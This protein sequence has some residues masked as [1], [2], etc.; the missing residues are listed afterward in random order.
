MTTPT[1]VSHTQLNVAPGST[2]V[3]RDAEW[4]VTNTEATQDGLRISAQG[5]SELVRDTTATFY[6]ALDDIRPLDPREARVVADTSP[7][8]QRARLWLDATLRKGALPLNESKLTVSTR[9]LSDSLEYQRSAVR[10]ALDPANLRPRMLIADAVGL[11]KTIE[12]GMILSELVR[13]GR[14]ERILI[15]TPKHVLEQMQHEMWTRFALPFVRLDSVGI[16]RVRQQLPATRNPFS[17]YK[18]VIIS[19]DTLKQAKYLAHLEKHRWDAVVIDESHNITGATQNNR[20]ARILAENAEAL[21]LASATPH[22]GKAE[23]FAEMMRLLEPTAVTPHGEVIPSEV[24]R[25]V[26]RRHR[27]SPEVR[28]EVGSDWAERMPLQNFRVDASPAEEAVADELADVWLHPDSGSSPYSGTVKGLFPWTLAKA[29]LS[30][31]AALAESVSE[32]IRRLGHSLTGEQRR[33]KEALERLEGL[34][35]TAL[36]QPSAKYNRLVEYMRQ[37]GIA[38]NSTERIVVFSERVAT[39]GWLREKIITDFRFKPEQVAVLHGGLSDVEQQEVVESFKQSSSA[40]RVLITGDVASEGVNLHTQCHELVHFDIPWSLIRIEQRNGRIDRYGQSDRPQITTLLLTPSNEKFT[41][42]I[43]VL[44]RLLEREEEAHQQLGDSASLM[45]KYNADAE[46][47]AIMEALERGSDIDTVVLSVDEAFAATGDSIGALLAQIASTPA[48]EQK[49]SADTYPGSGLF[50]SDLDYLDTA[51]SE[52]Y[53]TP[54]ETEKHG[55]VSWREHRAHGTAELVPPRDLVRRLRVLPQSYLSSRKVTE[56]LVL[57]TK[58][59]RASILLRDAVNNPQSTTIWPEAHFLGPLHPVLDWMSDRTLSELSRNEVFAVHTDVEHPTVL[60]QGSLTN[61]RGHVVALSLM[62]VE[63]PNPEKPSFAMT[64]SH[65][66]ARE[67]IAKIGL[68]SRLVNTG[69]GIDRETAQQLISYAYAQAESAIDGL[70]S[71]S[72]EDITTRV[73]QWARRV[74][75]WA[76]EAAGFTQIKAL[77]QRTRTVE[78]EREIATSML[79]NQQLIRP[80]LVAMPASEE[81]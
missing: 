59:E 49:D 12:I 23:S 17:L 77:R 44:K 36:E 61:A 30:S 39:L 7:Q 79:P 8:H 57:A 26:I 51:L 14:G 28:D 68:T 70:M 53:T 43:R 76:T 33:E 37:V 3:V 40:I 25:L 29:F 1:E 35:R 38:K 62:T 32:R 78:Q 46:E 52:V 20:L 64:E 80:L 60:L 13:R 22:N 34:T 45:G 5:L 58:R 2:V 56:H 11:G 15:V 24:E 67:A 55:G 42:D 71:A 69:E 6:E 9:M 10:K 50:E 74:D 18:R 72:R 54:S 16:Q 31:P 21:L 47:K 41:G 63:F 19:I 4:L 27:N 75:D 48:D 81:A 73:R 66:S 65:D